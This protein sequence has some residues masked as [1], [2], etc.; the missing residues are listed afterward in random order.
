M[1][2]TVTIKINYRIGSI[3]SY[4]IVS[5]FFIYKTSCYEIVSSAYHLSPSP[6]LIFFNPMLAAEYMRFYNYVREVTEK[7]IVC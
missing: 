3:V 5:T 1:I 4:R 2:L 7:L 6:H